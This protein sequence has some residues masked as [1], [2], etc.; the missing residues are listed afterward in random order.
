MELPKHVSIKMIMDKECF[1]RIKKG[2]L[3]CNYLS[4]I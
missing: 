1:V 3:Y 2:N 4:I